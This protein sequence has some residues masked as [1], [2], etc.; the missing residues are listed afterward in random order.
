MTTADLISNYKRGYK[1]SEYYSVNKVMATIRR[2]WK[3]K[4]VQPSLLPQAE[5]MSEINKLSPDS[6]ID[7]VLNVI[8]S[9]MTLSSLDLSAGD[10]I[11]Y[12]ETLL[13]SK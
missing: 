7:T 4:G 2:T 9:V 11:E 6:S 13:T 12:F 8:S 5:I 3:N 10:F 1:L